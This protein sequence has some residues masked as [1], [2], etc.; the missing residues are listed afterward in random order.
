MNYGERAKNLV[1]SWAKE[2][3]FL[4]KHSDIYIHQ[5]KLMDAITNAMNET[6]AEGLKD[7]Y[8]NCLERMKLED[9]KTS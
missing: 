2:A 8:K 9:Q 7:G 6:Y 1:V 4:P 5:D 3:G